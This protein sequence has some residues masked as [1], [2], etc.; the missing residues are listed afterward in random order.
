MPGL[1]SPALGMLHPRVHPSS[2]TAA[3]PLQVL[4][5]VTLATLPAT[6]LYAL[7]GLLLSPLLIPLL[8]VKAA[9]NLAIMTP[10]LLLVS[11][12]AIP[13]GF[14]VAAGCLACRVRT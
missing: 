10:L 3:L 1:S 14:F 13:V 6:A 12:V 8:M 2:S 7:A 5:L 11:P 4:H 9:V